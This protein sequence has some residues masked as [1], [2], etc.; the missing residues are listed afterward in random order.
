[1]KIL[2]VTTSLFRNVSASI[3]NVALIN[4]MIENDHEVTV[5]TLDFKKELE[6]NFLKKELDKKAKVIKLKLN[7]YNKLSNNINEILNKKQNI[8]YRFKNLI[9][10][11]IFF[12]DVL[13][14]SIKEIKK[15]NLEDKFDI[16][17]SSSD[18][19]TSHF[20]AEK[21]KE[22]SQFK[23]VE[24]I[25]I[26]GDPW[27][28]D[29]GLKNINLFMKYRIKKNEEKLLK[30]ASKIFYISELTKNEMQELYPEI[31]NKVF[32]LSRSY[33]KE[34]KNTV[35]QNNKKIIFLYAGT[36]KNRNI[37]PLIKNI[38]NYN[39]RNNIKIEL[40]LYGVEY[41]E[42]FNEYN[43]L[44]VYSKVSY[45]EIL[46]EYSKVDV[47]VYIDNINS[48]QI[49]GKLYDYYGTEKT[50]LTLCESKNTLELLSKGK[51]VYAYFNETNSINIDE[52]LRENKKNK[53]LESYSPKNVAQTLFNI[54]R[55]EN[56][57]EI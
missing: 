35:K 51:R 44:K 1:M 22:R 57:N 27:A 5:I 30:L 54:I 50:I 26:W 53:I 39:K 42:L 9:K 25:Q 21:I 14:E 19:K 46:K 48:N 18:S 10:E 28:T 36:L 15:I 24:W 47:L 37:I 17:I 40:K 32:L 16:I 55:E 34:I 6:D 4:G 45:E 56:Y 13:S 52:I 31:A 8:L 29:S 12:P 20:I 2:Y 7:L 43:F 23:K 49:P 38:E 3:R 33:L 11:N 41:L